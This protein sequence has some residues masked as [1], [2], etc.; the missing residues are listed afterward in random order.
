M[1]LRISI[2]LLMLLFSIITTFAQTGTTIPAAY[3]KDRIIVDGNLNENDWEKAEVITGF[4]RLEP[5][6]GSPASRKTEVRI[7]FGEDDLY[8][9]ARM[10][11]DP[12]EVENVLGRRDEFNRADWFMISIDSYFNRRTSYTFAVNAAGV[13]LDGQQGGRRVYST[14]LFDGLDTSWDAIWFSAVDITD[15]GWVAELRIPYSMLRFPGS[16]EQTWGIH[17]M[18]RIQRL[19]E[20]SEWPYIPRTERTNLVA[21]YGQMTGIRDLEP[22]RNVQVRPY[23]LSGVD[24]FENPA[25]PGKGTHNNRLDIGGDIKVGLGTNIMM[26]A[27]INPDF[28]QVEADPAVLNLTA[29]ETFY[30]ERR[31]FF[32]E[33]AD[34][35]QFGIGISRL[36]YSRRI[37][38]QD[39][40]SGAAKV[41]GRSEGGLS[42]GILGATAGES[43][44]PSHN[45]GVV[46]ATQQIGQYSSAGGII[47]AYH[48]PRQDGIGWQSLTGGAD[49]D[50]R[51]GDNRYSFEGITAFAER[52]SIVPGRDDESGFMSGLVM[53]K[54]EGTVDGHL[55]FL[56][57]SDHYNPNDIGWTSFE[58]NFYEIWPGLNYNIND[59]QPFGPFQRGQIRISGR[60]R[61]SYVEGWNMGDFLSLR[62]EWVTMGFQRI[63]AG[64]SFSEI[65]GGYDIWET[66]GL[67][68]WARP[69]HVAFTIE[70]NSDERESWMVTPEAGYKG[71]GDGGKVYSLALEGK[72][73]IGT[74]FSFTGGIDGEWER[75]YTAWASNETFTR[76]NGQ[77]AIGNI[78]APPEALTPDDFTVFDDGGLLDPL[79]GR[80]DEHS[81]GYWYLPVFGERD[82][83][84]LD[85]TLR[86]AVT[87]TSNLSFQLYTQ[88]FLAKGTYDNFSILASPDELTGFDPFP[89]KRD[90]SYRN[91]QSNFVT[92]W[93]YR[94]GSTFYLVWSHSRRKRDEMN[95]LAP[96]GA[97]PYDRELGK[98]VGDL[99]A[100]FP[101][102]TIMLKFNYAF[103]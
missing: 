103:F 12:E 22:R 41:S 93:E 63:S 5:S 69:H 51:F 76:A 56:I 65:M 27:T 38:A 1:Y 99:F 6:E 82:T 66:R 83:R 4:I 60:Q 100:V 73:D 9:G 39:P 49:W 89:K 19:G 59:G 77:W 92:R 16:E 32:T 2:P 91:L 28:G 53:R 30:T 70:Y 10:Y 74:R 68:R 48:S 11:D 101:H 42:F 36:F 98:Q 88:M 35:F 25:E 84:A 61:Y 3:T 87:L 97:S 8:V 43:F 21:R 31:P 33:G 52:R 58:Q 44:N 62:S 7:L 50:V 67:G 23:L 86:S 47:T 54:R 72:I 29:F 94:P 26:D 55:T 95:P 46:R 71:F 64:A 96:W 17:F 14:G 45:Y 79:T 13:Q 57:F 24:F 18:R 34:I 75:S 37:G 90:F 78:S 81:N 15:D 80:V 85:L 102:N 20:I 40:I